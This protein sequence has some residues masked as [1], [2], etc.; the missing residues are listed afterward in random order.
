MATTVDCGICC[1]TYNLKNH[2][3]IDCPF[4]DFNSCRECTQKYVVSTA[5]DAHCMSCKTAWNRE[6]V[7]DSCTKKFFT[8][9]YKQHRET[10]LLE[11]ERCLLPQTQ[12]LVV[13]KKHELNL[14]KMIEECRKEQ[15]RARAG[16]H[17]LELQLMRI[18]NGADIAPTPNKKVFIRKCP[19]ENCRGF[20]GTNWKCDLCDR[21]TCSKCNEPDTG[22]GHTC[23][24]NNVET[25]KLLAKDTKP[26][27]ACGTMIFKISGCNQMWCPDCHT[28]FDWRTGHIETG[29]IHNPHFYDF[30]RQINVGAQPNRNTGD[31]PCGGAPT[32]SELVQFFHPNARNLNQRGY[33]FHNNRSVESN[34]EEETKLMHLHRAMVHCRVYEAPLY[35]EIADNN[36]DLRVSYLLDDIPEVEW[37]RQLQ[38]REKA[39]YKSR[40]IR[41]LLRMFTD[42]GGDYLRQMIVQQVTVLECVTVLTALVDYFN[43]TMLTIHRRYGCVTPW[44]LPATYNVIHNTYKAETTK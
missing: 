8:T 44:I 10:I 31:I 9:E 1:E 14:R 24:P 43:A 33:Y 28:A 34:S 4:C 27:P 42:T 41:S 22:E 40:D 15:I 36:T 7:A 6:F 11:R 25:A 20:L 21:K 37:K 26:C 30:Q 29:T 13:R 38:R 19:T 12:A 16:R 18:Q 17:D 5:N 35:P 32:V 2:K 23:D 39:Q 3:K